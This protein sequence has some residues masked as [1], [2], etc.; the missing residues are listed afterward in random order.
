MLIASI[1]E[2]ANAGGRAKPT[3]NIAKSNTAYG[4]ALITIRLLWLRRLTVSNTKSTIS[5]YTARGESL[6]ETACLNT[7][8]ST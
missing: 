5:N 2:T 8:G 4:D 3:E 1:S 6:T 7:S